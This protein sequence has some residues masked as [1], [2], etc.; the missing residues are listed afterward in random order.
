MPSSLP[1]DGTIIVD[2]IG[3]EYARWGDFVLKTVMQPVFG[4]DGDTISACGAEAMVGPHKAGQA[5]GARDFLDLLSRTERQRVDALLRVLHVGNHANLGVPGLQLFL[6]WRSGTRGDEASAEAELG[7]MRRRLEETEPAP[8]RIVVEIAPAESMSE[9]TSRELARRV[10]ESGFAVAID[11]FGAG[12]L[13]PEWLRLL[14]PDV[15][16][17][18]GAWFRRICASPGASQLLCALVGQLRGEG[19]KV[20]VQGIETPDQFEVALETGADYLQGF[21]LARPA[22]AGTFFDEAPVPVARA[23]R[24]DAEII[25][26]FG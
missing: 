25:P 23:L 16:K 22:L 8:A 11:D 20:L 9:T 26:L 21:L 15:V 12:G 3:I 14:R 2:E 6:N 1:A 10:R 4:R 18:G 7:L 24:R 13:E 17:L 5:V 19:A